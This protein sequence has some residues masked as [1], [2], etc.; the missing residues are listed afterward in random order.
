MNLE[1]INKVLNPPVLPSASVSPIRSGI[2]TLKEGKIEVMT[3][4][5]MRSTS[6]DPVI[7]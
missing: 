1:G 6:E 5:P 2:T 7:T 4:E 3:S